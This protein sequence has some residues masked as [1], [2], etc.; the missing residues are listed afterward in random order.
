VSA[1][2]QNWILLPE[3]NQTDFKVKWP[4]IGG[5]AKLCEGSLPDNLKKP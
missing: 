5:N 2:V 3:Q 4:E 1:L